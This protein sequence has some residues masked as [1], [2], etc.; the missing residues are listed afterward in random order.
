MSGVS[1]L[2]SRGRLGL[3]GGLCVTCR[4]FVISGGCV[5][6][7]TCI[8]WILQLPRDERTRRA[9]EASARGERTRP[10]AAEQ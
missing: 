9:H 4:A 7:S 6:T 8:F 2:S 1:P 10:S 5:F 3:G